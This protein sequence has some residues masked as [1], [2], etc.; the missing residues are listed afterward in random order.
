[1]NGIAAAGSRKAQRD[2]DVFWEMFPRGKRLHFSFQPVVV[3]FFFFENI[4]VRAQNIQEGVS[5]R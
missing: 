3:F 1:M 2:S 4:V 5:S